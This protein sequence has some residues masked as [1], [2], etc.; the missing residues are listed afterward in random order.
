MKARILFLLKYLFFW[1]S[2]FIFGKIVFLLYEHDQSF[3]LPLTDWFLILLHGFRLD[4]STAGYFLLL[5]TLIIAL[6]CPLKGQAA[7]YA[8]NVY[9]FI[10][11][12]AFLLITLVD[13]EIYKYWGSR[14]DSAPLRFLS[15]PGDVLASSSLITLVLYF[16]AFG[17]LSFFLFWILPA[18]YNKTAKGDRKR[19]V[20]RDPCFPAY[21]GVINHTYPRRFQCVGY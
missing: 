11:L 3:A 19:R 2:L 12:I 18:A 15:T 9:T 14:L 21:P 4:L 13:L 8:I 17:F 20:C 7:Y 10:L 6:T 5:P 16:S 1:L